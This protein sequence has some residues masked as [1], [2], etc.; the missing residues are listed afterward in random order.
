MTS[1][2]LFAW[3]R[4]L[5]T[6]YPLQDTHQIALKIGVSDSTIRRWAHILGLTKKHAPKKRGRTYERFDDPRYQ[7]WRLG[8]L[9]RANFKCQRCGKAARDKKNGWGLDCHHILSW[10]RH[11]DVRFDVLNGIAFCRRCHEHQHKT[12]GW[13]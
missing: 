8:V 1:K 4:Y 10:A 5:I 12:E 2:R 13:L 9:S 7:V 6:A 11:P 3:R